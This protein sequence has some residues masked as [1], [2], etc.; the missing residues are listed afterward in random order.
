[1]SCDL[2]NSIRVLEIDSKASDCH[3]WVY[4][5]R[6]G[7]GYAPHVPNVCGG[8]YVHLLVC[9]DCGKVQ[10]KFPVV[11]EDLAE[12]AEDSDATK[13]FWD[14][15]GNVE[16]E[17]YYLGRLNPM[18]ITDAMGRNVVGGGSGHLLS[19][20]CS[21]EVE[22]FFID[23]HPDANWGHGCLYVLIDPGNNMRVYELK[24]SWPPHHSIEGV[25][26]TK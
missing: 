6:D 17:S 7:D 16:G 2:C 9:L 18:H 23:L 8:D 24:D 10:G 4:M 3:G 26:I 15:Y 12:S 11:S 19:P 21:K 22:C 5:G 20:P 1:M 13:H 25:K 14:N